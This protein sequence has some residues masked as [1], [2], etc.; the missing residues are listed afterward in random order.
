M[1]RG[2]GILGS[3]RSDPGYRCRAP[4]G[5]E[6]NGTGLVVSSSVSR[7]ILTLTPALSRSGGVAAPAVSACADSIRGRGGED[8]EGVREFLG[9]RGAPTQAVAV[10]A[11]LGLEKNGTG[12]GTGLVVSPSVSRR[13]RFLRFHGA[14]RRRLAKAGRDSNDQSKGLKSE[15]TRRRDRVRSG[16]F[17]LVGRD[18]NGAPSPPAPLPRGERGE[19][20]D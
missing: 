17:V 18:T 6:K 1:D 4:L 2:L 16:H 12:L 14:V 9:L 3:L 11:L 5:L 15:I 20:V 10:R 19:D 8:V 7:E 13:I